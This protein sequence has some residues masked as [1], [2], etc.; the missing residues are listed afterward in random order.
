MPFFSIVIPLYNKEHFIVQTIQ[1]V[2]DQTFQDYEILVVNDGSIDASLK[3]LSVF[4][5]S[6][7]QVFTIKNQGVSHARNFG[8][9]KANAEYIAFLDADDLWLN[10]HLEQ[11]KK[12]LEDFPNCGLYANAYVKKMGEIVLGSDYIDIPNAWNG[13]VKDYF[14]SSQFSCVAWTSA[15]MVP[16]KIL[17]AFNGFDEKITLGAGEDTDLWMKIAIQHPIAF[18]NKVTAVY[19]LHADNRISNANTNLRR[20]LDLD[21]YEEAAKS[22]AS[23]KKYLDFNRFSIALQYKLVG[24]KEKMDFYLKHLNK[25]NLNAKQR[26]ILSCNKSTLVFLMK[27]QKV[28]RQFHVNLS[29][30]K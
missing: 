14:K 3:S 24:N 13:I 25:R 29:P 17:E 21:V 22:N 11:L 19:N 7:I 12:L 16:K 5:D 8:I 23:L 15:V 4:K 27:T 10:K 28:L 6:R 26:F 9:K 18:N 1:S 20:F 30:F 2:L